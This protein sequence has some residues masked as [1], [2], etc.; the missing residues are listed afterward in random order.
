MHG[1]HIGMD[2][3]VNAADAAVRVAKSLGRNRVATDVMT[4]DT[5]ADMS[6]G[7]VS[8]RSPQARGESA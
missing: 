4:A 7:T 8:P 6:G 1:R 5:S 2:P 3:L